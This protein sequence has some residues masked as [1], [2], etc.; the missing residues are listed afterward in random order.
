MP[1]EIGAGQR[2]RLFFSVTKDVS[3]EGFSR[4]LRYDGWCWRERHTSNNLQASGPSL[5]N[6][7]MSGL[8]RVLEAVHDQQPRR[9]ARSVIYG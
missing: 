3:S 8:E 2:K 6:Y 5:L 9:L 7:R 1:V 4:G